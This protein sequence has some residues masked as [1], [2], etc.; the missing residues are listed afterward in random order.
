MWYAVAGVVFGVIGGMGMG[1]GIILIPA[2]TFIFALD[3]HTAQGMNLLAFL[4]MAATALI[5]HIR[6]KRIEK[7][8]CVYMCIGGALGAVAGAVCASMI[9]SELLRK[10]FG[11]FLI[12]LSGAR[13]FAQI[14]AR[15]KQ[16]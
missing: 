9:D 4:P 15:A 2:L 12:L 10:I 7:S 6:N 11:G 14:K 3:Q 5:F 16:L 1:G 13:V 8:L